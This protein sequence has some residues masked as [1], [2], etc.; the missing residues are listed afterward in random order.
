MLLEV[1]SSRCNPFPMHSS[2]IHTLS[3]E[4]LN[5]TRFKF[6]S[7]CFLILLL[8]HS[9]LNLNPLKRSFVCVGD[10]KNGKSCGLTSKLVFRGQL[11][12]SSCSMV[13]LFSFPSNPLSQNHKYGWHST[14]N[15]LC[16][17][18]S[19]VVWATQRTTKS[20]PNDWSNHKNLQPFGLCAFAI[21]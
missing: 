16:Q 7:Y 1:Y 17:W 13:Q 3:S 19:R 4:D 8:L 9:N 14:I 5:Y 2:L 21:S 11:V 18:L 10:H 20:G 15:S 12:K 6:N